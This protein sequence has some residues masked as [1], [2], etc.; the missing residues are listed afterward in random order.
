MGPRREVNEHNGYHVLKQITLGETKL[1]LRSEGSPAPVGFSIS[2]AS[3][4]CEGF[5]AQEFVRDNGHGVLLPW[6]A[7]LT[8]G[9]GFIDKSVAPAQ[10]VQVRAYS[11]WSSA[12]GTGAPG[13]VV[14]VASGRCG[15]LVLKFTP[16]PNRNYLARLSYP[17]DQCSLVIMDATDPDAPTPVDAEALNCPV[18]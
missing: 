13:S 2:S 5:S 7:K 18:P 1:V 4:N 14:S 16:A 3:Q 10:P 11:N 12:T 6:I 15:P 17:G 8:A 9:R